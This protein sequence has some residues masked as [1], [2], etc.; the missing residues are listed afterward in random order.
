MVTYIL[1]QMQRAINEEADL[2]VSMWQGQLRNWLYRWRAVYDKWS[3][4][5]LVISYG[6]PKIDIQAIAT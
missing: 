4:H 2:V 3:G 6:D 5:P 1:E